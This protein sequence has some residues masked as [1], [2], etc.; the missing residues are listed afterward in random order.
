M[1]DDG[2]TD[3]EV[4]RLAGHAVIRFERHFPVPPPVVWVALTDPDFLSKWW[5]E[6]TL[7]LR[8][9]GRFDV[10]WFNATPS[11]HRL[12][13]HGKVTALDPPHRLETT[14]DVHGILRWE[15]APE[16]GGTSTGGWRAAALPPT[17]TMKT[18]ASST[19]PNPKS[20]ERRPVATAARPSHTTTQLLHEPWRSGLRR[21]CTRLRRLD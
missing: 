6:V 18:A 8:L 5:G 15:L 11:G 1:I 21:N 17:S 3:G 9:G 16:S 20:H 10:C 12:T 2:S 4:T 7:D 13:M 14:G 19:T